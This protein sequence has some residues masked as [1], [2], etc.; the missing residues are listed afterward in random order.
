LFSTS[1][2]FCRLKTYC[3]RSRQVKGVTVWEDNNSLLFRS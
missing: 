1:S 2:A 3:R